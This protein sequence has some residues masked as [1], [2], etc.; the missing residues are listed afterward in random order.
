LARHKK[1]ALGSGFFVPH[2]EVLLRSKGCE[3]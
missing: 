3:D 2:Y 1:S